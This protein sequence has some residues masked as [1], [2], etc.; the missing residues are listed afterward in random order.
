MVWDLQDVLDNLL[1]EGSSQMKYLGDIDSMLTHLDDKLNISPIR[2][3]TTP[4]KSA[5]NKDRDYERFETRQSL[6]KNMMD[7]GVQTIDSLEHLAQIRELEKRHF[8]YMMETLKNL[9]FKVDITSN[10]QHADSKA[11]YEEVTD[12]KY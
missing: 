12:S 6:K 8:R 4:T 11:N 9:R 2:K 10:L 7:V 5:K 1:H 3:S